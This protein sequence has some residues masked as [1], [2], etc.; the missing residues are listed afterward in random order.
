MEKLEKI[1][2]EMKGIIIFYIIVAVLALILT[3]KIEDINSQAQNET[4][5]KTYYA[6]NE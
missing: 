4:I 1:F 2:K 3:N 6:Y 5:E